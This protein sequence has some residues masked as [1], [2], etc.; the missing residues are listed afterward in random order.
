MA[1]QRQQMIYIQEALTQHIPPLDE[2]TYA[3]N[4]AEDVATLDAAASTHTADDGDLL[5][6]LLQSEPSPTKQ[7]KG[8][9]TVEPRNILDDLDELLGGGSA[10]APPTSATAAAAPQAISGGMGSAVE[11]EGLPRLNDLLGGPALTASDASVATPQDKNSF[12]A[13]SHLE[14]GVEITFGC[15]PGPAGA[16]DIAAT[17]VN[18]GLERMEEFQ[19]SSHDGILHDVTVS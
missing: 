9:A 10:A 16:V 12:V 19:V 11:G 2:A 18:R 6:D 14:H 4:L 13:W 5:G 17:Y 7:P 8:D 3:G 1:C 15:S